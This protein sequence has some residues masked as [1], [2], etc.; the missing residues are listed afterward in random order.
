MY[1]LLEIISTRLAN[2][3]TAVSQKRQPKYRQLSETILTMINEGV[4]KPGD[5]LPTETVLARGLPFSLGTIQQALRN[6]SELGVI[7][8]T[9]RSGTVITDRTQEIFALWQFRFID[10]DENSVFP[11]FSKVIKLDRIRQR[12]TWSNFLGDGDSFIRIIREI[13]V[14]HRFRAVSYFYLAH[15]QFS[16]IL[17]LSPTELEGVHLSAVIQRMFGISTVRTNNRVV[18]SVI[19]DQ[20]CLRLGLPSGARG[21]IC[22]ILG[23]GPKD[24]PLSF[25]QAYIPADVEPM[26]FRELKPTWSS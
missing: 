22:Q 8:R 3:E 13:D 14:G 24:K 20:I 2:V 9:Q 12:G 4:L 16:A 23:F 1:D 7:K 25:Q 18:C 10:E 17:D 6:L 21:L 5:R 26:E 11:V 15:N 19:P